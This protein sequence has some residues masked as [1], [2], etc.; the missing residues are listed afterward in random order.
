MPWR[1]AREMWVALEVG[2]RRTNQPRLRQQIVGRFPETWEARMT[3]VAKGKWRAPSAATKRRSHVAF[4]IAMLLAR[5][6]PGTRVA[7]SAICPA[8]RLLSPGLRCS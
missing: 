2:H 4:G 7:C 3:E 1:H 6:R 8:L 5:R